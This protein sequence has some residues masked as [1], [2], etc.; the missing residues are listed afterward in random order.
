MQKGYLI[1]AHSEP[2]MEQFVRNVRLQKEI[3]PENLTEVLSTGDIHKMLPFLNLNGIVGGTFNRRDGHTNPFHCTQAYAEAAKRLG[4]EIR[5][6]TEIVEIKTESG[7]VTGVV[8]NKGD[9][10][11]TPVVV[12]CAGPHG[13]LV[14]KMVG[15]DIPMYPERHQA[16]V[17]EPLEMF[18]PCMV[19]DFTHGTWCKQTPE[20]SLFL[21]VG[22]PEHE[23][24]AITSQNT[25][26]FVEDAARKLIT[27]MPILKDVVI[28]RQW[29]GMYDM[30]PDSQAI[31]GPTPVGGFYLDIGWSGHGY[32]V[33]PIVGKVLAE[34]ISGQKP[35]IDVSCMNLDR[36]EKGALIPEP[37]CV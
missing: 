28:V 31:I 3:D 23:L 14:G 35:A 1:L 25:W 15:L 8:T 32:Q 13:T 17:T 20:G 9:V 24:K 26:Q 19:L 2:Q 22:D 30:T 29:T 10:I 4:A 27:L 21:G 18:L 5:T 36:F 11:N 12:N 16:L 6:Y 37:F 33:G 34:M 7:H